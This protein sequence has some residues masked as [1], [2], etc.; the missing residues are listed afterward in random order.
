MTVEIQKNQNESP[1]LA[2]VT[3]GGCSGL[4]LFTFLILKKKTLF[5]SYWRLAD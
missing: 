3:P 1:L 5:I 2:K 4:L